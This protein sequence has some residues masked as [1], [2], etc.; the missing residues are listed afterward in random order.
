MENPSSTLP[1][2]SAPPMPM[3][4]FPTHANQIVAAPLN[5]IVDMLSSVATPNQTLPIGGNTARLLPNYGSVNMPQFTPIV[6][7][8]NPP[9][10]LPQA[11]SSTTDDA[12][13][14]FR[15]EMAKTLRENFGVELPRNWIYQKPY[16]EYFDA[17]P[18]PQGYK[19]PDFVKFN[20]EGM[21]TTWEHVSQ[22]LA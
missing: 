21:K 10:P 8:S 18:C 16:P 3:N 15:E 20:G 14:N 6:A 9:M 4:Y 2:S 19:I 12:L 22:Y 13:A 11:S 17:I 1:I 5:L 7:N